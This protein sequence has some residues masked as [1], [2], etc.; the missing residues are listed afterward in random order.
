M[1]PCIQAMAHASDGHSGW[2]RKVLLQ[3]VCSSVGRVIG[4]IL[5]ALMI[6]IWG[7]S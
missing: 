1:G 4:R 5:D 6:V 2:L 3:I 7:K